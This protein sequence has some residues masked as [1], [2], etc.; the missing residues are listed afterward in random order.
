M[1]CDLPMNGSKKTLATMKETM[2]V[3]SGNTIVQEKKSPRFRNRFDR[4][5]YAVV[6]GGARARRVRIVAQLPG[7]CALKVSNRP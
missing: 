3:M 5:M 4:I 2:R 6:R 1:V 7:E